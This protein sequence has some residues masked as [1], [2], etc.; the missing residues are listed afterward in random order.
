MAKAD[1]RPRA[2]REPIVV[3]PQR[4]VSIRTRLFLSDAEAD[5]L[6]IVGGH[7]GRL[8]A[9]DL[10]ARCRAGVDH[11]AVEW[12]RRKRDLTPESSARWAGAITRANNALWTTA[13]RNQAAHLSSLRSSTHAISRRLAQP[14][15]SPGGEL[16]PAGYPTKAAWFG[17]A[18]RLD[19]LR[20]RLRR[21]EL[22]HQAG[23]VHVTI[24]GKKLARGRHGVDD[25]ER[26]LSDWRDR[27]SAARLYLAAPGESGKKFGNQTIQVTPDGQVSV[28]LPEPLCAMANDVHHRLTL[29]RR[30]AFS[31]RG[32]QWADRVRA[33]GSVA[34]AISFAP[35][36]RRWY[37][38]ATWQPGNQ[39]TDAP[40]ARGRTIG[41][42]TNANHL[43]AW[44]L[45]ENGNPI[46]APRRFALDLSGA[47]AHRDAQVRHAVSQL[48]HWARR[49][50]TE[51]IAV[52]DLDFGRSKTREHFGKRKWFR[53]LVS[54]FPT[55][56]VQSRLGAMASEAGLTVIAVDAAYT[57]RWGK[58]HWL[59]AMPPRFQTTGHDA[60]AIVIGRRAQGLAARRRTPPPP[61]HRSDGAGHR[62]VQAARHEPGR[63]EVRPDQTGPPTGSARPLDR[64]TRRT[65]V[66]KTVRG[67]RDEA[68]T[69]LARRRGT[70]SHGWP[71]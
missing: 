23:H 27:W 54:S 20:A 28:R 46:G 66:P 42:D 34:Y 63:E 6:R 59:H 68:G 10:K 7:L 70:V 29:S 50:G 24:G 31:H 65:S 9:R 4:A 55:T 39:V 62:S 57:T 49:T 11:D 13:R 64:G 38:T 47:T 22:D 14:V 33:N 12:A 41:V 1:K 58:Q 3:P 40:I 5:T 35:D 71:P 67:T 8:A 53:N 45:D 61:R 30:I 48:L 16:S 15:G 60:A 43:A 19:V 21:V 69:D 36:R 25:V 2:L 51:V 52:E 44:Q 26:P 37:I 18:R 56:H 17:K 32:A